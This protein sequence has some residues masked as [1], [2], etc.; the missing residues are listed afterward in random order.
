MTEGN[1]RFDAEERQQG[2]A[3]LPIYG[4]EKIMGRASLDPLL[5][6]E[7]PFREFCTPRIL[8]RILVTRW[9]V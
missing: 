8:R 1:P 3:R 6:Q 2:L 7:G 9:L 5:G 4:A